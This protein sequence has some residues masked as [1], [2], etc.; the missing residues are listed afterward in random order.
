MTRMIQTPKQKP[1]YVGEAIPGV[2]TVDSGEV[3]P[4]VHTLS[5]SGLAPGVGLGGG[6][7]FAEVVGATGCS[8]GAGLSEFLVPGE[9]SEQVGWDD[10]DGDDD[11]E[12]H[13]L[14]CHFQ[15]PET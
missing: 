14:D 9:T 15:A 12:N 11:D 1:D 7:L 3:L 4:L 6:E 10:D 8:V 13:Y 2:P 5:E